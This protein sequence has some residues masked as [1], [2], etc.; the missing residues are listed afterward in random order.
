MQA[1]GVTVVRDGNQVA[2]FVAGKAAVKGLVDITL[3]VKTNSNHSRF[4]NERR[5]SARKNAVAALSS[6]NSPTKWMTN[7][8]A[9]AAVT[10]SNRRDVKYS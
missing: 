7:F 9:S 5:E 2:A 6:F 1:L 4:R 3:Q 10:S 8:S